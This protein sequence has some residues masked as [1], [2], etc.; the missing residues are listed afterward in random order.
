MQFDKVRQECRIVVFQRQ[1]VRKRAKRRE[2]SAVNATYPATIDTE[3]RPDY[4]LKM[5]RLCNLSELESSA[6]HIGTSLKFRRLQ[7]GL[8]QKV[9]ARMIGAT[10]SYVREIEQGLKPM[11]HEMWQRIVNSTSHGLR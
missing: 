3:S 2:A 6:S 10:V 7:L 9:L 11:V 1:S 5:K 8:S 4:K